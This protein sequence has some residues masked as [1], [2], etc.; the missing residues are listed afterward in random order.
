[1]IETPQEPDVEHLQAEA[2]RVMQRVKFFWLSLG[3]LVVVVVGGAAYLAF[4]SFGVVG[5]LVVVGAVV[6]GAIALGRFLLSF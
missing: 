5:A 2:R 6:L 4:Q 3:I 1:M